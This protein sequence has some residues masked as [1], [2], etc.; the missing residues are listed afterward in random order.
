M[1]TSKKR[2]L[3][4]LLPLL[5]I[6]AFVG[7]IFRKSLLSQLYPYPG[8]LLVSFYFP[9]QNAGWD[10]YNSF[11]S[12]KEFLASDAIRQIIPWRYLVI[13]HLKQGQI[14]LW[15]QY[16]FS[17]TPLL[18]NSQSAT[19]YPANLIFLV[20]PFFEAWV[21]HIILA[22]LL[23]SFFLYLLLRKYQ[24]S[25][26]AALM[27]SISFICSSYFLIWL[28]IGI[29]AHTVLWFPLI[30]WSIDQY[31]E[32]KKERY[33]ALLVTA[34][35]LTILAGHFQTGMHFLLVAGSYFLSSLLFSEQVK[36]N[37][38][39]IFKILVLWP[40]LTIGITCI[41]WL[42]TY[43]LKQLS[44]LAEG[45]AKDVY[46][47]IKTP[48][49]NIFTLFAPD[50]LGHPA[51]A[52]FVS[53]IYGDG[54]PFVSAIAV[55]L[56]VIAL[57]YRSNW[58]VKFWVVIGLVYIFYGFPGPIYHLVNWLHIDLLAETLSSRTLIIVIY[59][60]VLLSAW[61]LDTL[62]DLAEKRKFRKLLLPF[63]LQLSVLFIM[64]LIA[65]IG[66]KTSF[67]TI[68]ESSQAQTALRN[69]VIP[70]GI[71]GSTIFLTL[72]VYWKKN[73]KNLMYA[74]ILFMV[75]IHGLY[76][77]NKTLPFSPRE[78]FYPKHPM[79]SSAIDQ[80]GI[81]RT[82]GFANGRFEKT[83]AP[84]YQLYSPEGY[85]SLRIKR[86]AELFEAHSNGGEVP[87][88]YSK[89][90][91]DFS[92]EGT[93]QRRRLLDLTGVRILFDKNQANRDEYNIETYKFPY[94][95]VDLNWVWGPFR[96]Y[97]RI[98]GVHRASIVHDYE[99]IQDDTKILKRIYDPEFNPHKSVVL[100]SLPSQNIIS[101]SEIETDT[102]QVSEN[103]ASRIQ[104]KVNTN[105]PSLFVLSDAYFPGWKAFVNGT[106]T[107]ILRA[108][109]AFRSIEIPTGE[110]TILFEYKPKSFQVGLVV[111]LLS[112]GSFIALLLYAVGFKKAKW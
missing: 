100:E 18:A 97:E 57:L 83:F 32:T 25:V 65:L 47:E 36:G 107:K 22:P 34:S 5:I 13:E 72:L 16:S 94:D 93:W 45:F 56:A 19:F 105:K 59:C 84:M 44:P 69:L 30:I 38:K 17:G 70:I 60:L 68:F 52:N 99:V 98:G 15:N 28:E 6:S 39:K 1:K 9:W 64:G 87:E 76:Q 43:E 2:L 54:T 55:F 50:Y 8:N 108:N 58:R 101:T 10:G 40:I 66:W 35:V 61:G 23:A 7:L 77:A 4:R 63:I 112:S 29:V 78:Y 20:L 31:L 111:S 62:I 27:G 42:P 95:T 37:R 89:S 79:I 48:W 80:A 71:T 3:N 51:T 103:N 41:Q 104:F 106:E 74:G 26:W 109:Y 33:F 73:T 92:K 81:D 85:D 53:D 24:V 14:P 12:S 49:L 21:L 90:D 86:Y 46:Q 96:V 110:S 102:I 67:V 88:K 11:T 75:G 82:I 91:A